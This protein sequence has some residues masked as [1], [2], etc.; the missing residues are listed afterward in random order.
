MS[1]VYSPSE[2]YL[3]QCLAPG[4]LMGFTAHAYIPSAPG[5]ALG[6]YARA[7]LCVSCDL[8]LLLGYFVSNCSLFLLLCK[9]VLY[10]YSQIIYPVTVD[11]S[12]GF[13]VFF[14]CE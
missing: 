3:S 7:L 4:V 8:L 9:L 12:L 6:P 13:I 14:A 5:L 10:D 11:V 1:A 2:A